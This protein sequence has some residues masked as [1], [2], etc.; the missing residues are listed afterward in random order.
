[1]DTRLRQLERSGEHTVEALTERLRCGDLTRSQVEL[2]A[3]CGH[4]AARVVLGWC[5]FAPDND[6]CTHCR[7]CGNGRVSH[8][9][10]TLGLADWLR[11]LGW[12]WG[13]L[14]RAA[15]A[16]ARVALETF[17]CKHEDEDERGCWDCQNT[18]YDNA[19]GKAAERAIEAA[20]AWIGWPSVRRAM[21][22][23][24]AHFSAAAYGCGWTPQRAG[25]HRGS[26][27]WCSR[28]AGEQPV[29]EAICAALTEWALGPG[30]KA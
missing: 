11:G 19:E 27:L 14:L 22:W 2:A 18:G 17:E 16:A 29:R 26:C 7:H 15:V 28:L 10:E 4:E 20:E 8:H 6:A 5:R 12:W 13:A 9:P 30:G 23:D 1:M 24:R 21:A 3:Y 25:G